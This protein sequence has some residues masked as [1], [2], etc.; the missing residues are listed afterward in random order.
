[1]RENKQAAVPF[2]A[3]ERELTRG[4]FAVHFGQPSSLANEILLRAWHGGPA[5][6]EPKLPAAV[7]KYA[8]A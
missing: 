7:L 2:D 6:G 1:M 4:E 8:G 3:R 5:R